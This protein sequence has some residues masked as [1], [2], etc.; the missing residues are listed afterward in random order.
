M[1]DGHRSIDLER[2]ALGRYQATNARGG[3]IDIGQ[4]EDADFTPVELLLVALAGCSAVDVDHIVSKRAE[5]ERLSV[6][7]TGRKIRDEHGNRLSDLR[8]AFAA[9][10]PDGEA[11]DAARSVLADAVAKS[12]DRLCTV[13]RTVEVGSPVEAGVVD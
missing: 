10:F 11:G 8:L 7:S 2:V 1:D 9:T 5:P 3:S 4:G 6:A 13:S 12:H